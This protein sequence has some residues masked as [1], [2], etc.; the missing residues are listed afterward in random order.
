MKWLPLLGTCRVCKWL[1]CQ[2]AVHLKQTPEILSVEGLMGIKSVKGSKSLR[3]SDI[4]LWRTKCQ[5]R[6]RHRHLTNGQN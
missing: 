5:L 1:S 2:H 3:C 4:E 6:S